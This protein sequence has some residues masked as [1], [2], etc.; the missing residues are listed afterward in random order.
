[1]MQIIPEKL[2]VLRKAA[3]LTVQ[4]LA[5]EALV[6]RATI[7]RIENGRT[8]TSNG[9]TIKRLAKALGCRPE[10]LSTPPEDGNLLTA[11]AH[12]RSVKVEMNAASHNALLLIAAR[13]GEQAA[14]V[15]ELAPL[16][17]DMVAT[18]SLL[19]RR[20]NL[21][22]L[23]QHRDA[24]SEMSDRFPHLAE[25]FTW[26]WNAASFDDREER[27]IARN[28]LRGEFVHAD[29]TMDDHFYPNDYDESADN[30]FVAH[31]RRRWGQISEAGYQSPTIEAM[32]RWTGPYY[33]I[34]IAEAG[35]I[36]GGDENLTAAI[37]SGAIPIVSIPT[38]LRNEGRMIERQA[39]MRERIAEN[40]ERADA[41]FKD[42]GIDTS[43]FE[44]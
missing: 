17:F 26:D 43:L 6:G 41:I 34:G 19:E 3:R 42:L 20:Q 23:R 44:E 5:E 32:P 33:E 18:E 8:S 15:L 40:A 1:M 12:R 7:T 39:W 4:K 24:I 9:T 28:D 38:D 35:K 16:L 13:Y 27:S 25:R 11:L 14:T 29:E 21:A 10:E 37:V 30:P 22:V 2:I 31:L 36:A